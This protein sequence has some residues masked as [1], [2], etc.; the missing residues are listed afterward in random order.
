[1]LDK[2]A[3]GS[4]KDKTVR[5]VGWS[6]VDSI[7][8]YGIGF[9]VGLV[10]ARLLSPNEYGLIGILTI[11]IN[12]FNTIIDSGF[13]TALIRRNDIKDIDYSTVFIVNL[14]VSGALA[15]LMFFGA[16]HISIFFDRPELTPITQVMSLILVINAIGIIQKTRLTKNIDFKTQTKISIIS[17]ISSGVIGIVLA[18]T[19]FGVWA[20]VAQQLSARLFTT[21]LLWIYNKWVPKLEFSGESFKALFGFSWKLL[22]AQIFNT[23]WRELYKFVVGKF[24]LPATLGLY[25]RAEQFNMIF[26]SNI[27]T[28]VQ[29]VSL[30]TLSAIK[31][32]TARMVDAY[33]RIIR[34]TMLVTSICMFMLAAIAKPLILVLLGPKWIG[35]VPFI[36]ILCFNYVLYPLHAL[37]INMMTLQGR[38]DLLLILQI[39]K[40]VITLIPIAI[41]IWIGIYWMLLA[42]VL[43]GVVEYFLNSYYSG[44]TLNYSSWDQIKDVSPAMII[45]ILVSGIVFSLSFLPISHLAILPMQLV[46]GA[47]LIIVVMNYYKLPEYVELKGIVLEYVKKLRTK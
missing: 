4:L 22:V 43:L 38:S 20:L 14:A 28:V 25:T 29:R 33:R 44:K 3:S 15:L 27:T 16:P 11:F 1:M 2:M 24:Y 34:S 17:H 45:S 35:C 46:L 12:V 30:P 39:L 10:L 41:G 37:N 42:S 47:G 26:S 18:L 8:N 21:T 32:E 9:I 36:Q 31:D 19:G 23:A 6:S 13:S 5:G 40:N 7:A